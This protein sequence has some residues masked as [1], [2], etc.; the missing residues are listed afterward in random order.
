MSTNYKK[1]YSSIFIV[2]LF[3]AMT[4]YGVFKLNNDSLLMK[5]LIAGIII[6]TLI[7]IY[8][9]FFSLAKFNNK[10]LTWGMINRRTCDWKDLTSI[11]IFTLGL[12]ETRNYI[13]EHKYQ[14]IIG[15][16]SI[17][18]YKAIVSQI[19]EILKKR[20]IDVPIHSSVK[21]RNENIIKKGGPNASKKH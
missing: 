15:L 7:C 20:G 12:G 5:I 3:T 2:I 9:F 11:E 16:L 13:F 21:E 4:I 6:F 8:S 1:I 18:N 14:L 19:D 17:R 10:G